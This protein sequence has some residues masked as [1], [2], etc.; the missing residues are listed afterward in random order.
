MVSS[1]S[2]WS[3]TR[4]SLPSFSLYVYSVPP[5]LTSSTGAHS[6]NGPCC[7]QGRLSSWLGFYLA[8]LCTAEA[9]QQSLQASGHSAQMHLGTSKVHLQPRAHFQPRAHTSLQCARG[10]SRL[11]MAVV[12]SVSVTEPMDTYYCA[13]ESVCILCVAWETSLVVVRDVF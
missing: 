12:S 1:H 4:V 11:R 13:S 8:W 2:Q 7:V 6:P 10:P 9:R 3:T 5:L